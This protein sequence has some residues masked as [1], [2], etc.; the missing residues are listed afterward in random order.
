MDDEGT[1]FQAAASINRGPHAQS[2]LEAAPGGD[3]LNTG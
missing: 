2:T 1:P 3:S